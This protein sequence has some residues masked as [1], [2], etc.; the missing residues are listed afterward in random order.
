MVAGVEL[1]GETTGGL[2]S[3]VADGSRRCV[4]SSCC[5]D[6]AARERAEVGIA[7]RIFF[8][9]VPRKAVSYCWAMAEFR[10]RGREIGQEDILYIRKLI[11]R[12]PKESR[13]KLS[14]RVCR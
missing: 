8:P 13:R 11:E 1:S 10:Y 4:A 6:V 5:A 12:Y 3:P 2:R 14:V 9:G 7:T